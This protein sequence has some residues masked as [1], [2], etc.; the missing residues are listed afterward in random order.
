[1]ATQGSQPFFRSLVLLMPNLCR[2]SAEHSQVEDARQNSNSRPLHSHLPSCYRRVLQLKRI[3][4]AVFRTY[5]ITLISKVSV[6][7][8]ITC[9]GS[10][11]DGV[12]HRIYF[13]IF[14][15]SCSLIVASQQLMLYLGR[16]VHIYDQGNL[17][18][19]HHKLEN[20]QENQSHVS[21]FCKR[22]DDA[23]LITSSLFNLKECVS[24]VI[25]RNLV[26]FIVRQ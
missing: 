26:H 17:S 1:M 14:P 16:H 4:T 20:L 23:C 6:C 22:N 12:G 18:Y 15:L 25:V 9:V 8:I 2:S 24:M 13:R 10:A 19:I 21:A 7:L 11:F 3:L 5:S